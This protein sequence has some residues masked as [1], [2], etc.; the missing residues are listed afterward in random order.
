MFFVS[1]SLSPDPYVSRMRVHCIH[2]RCTIQVV[3]GVEKERKTC[4]NNF[5]NN[6]NNNNT[7]QQLVLPDFTSFGAFYPFISLFFL[8]QVSMTD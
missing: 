2:V 3:K 6:N 1:F 4:L 8:T 7:M 5:P